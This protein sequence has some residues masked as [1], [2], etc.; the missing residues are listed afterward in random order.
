MRS[1]VPRLEIPVGPEFTDMAHRLVQLIVK[2]RSHCS[3]HR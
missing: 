2:V 3:L 1:I